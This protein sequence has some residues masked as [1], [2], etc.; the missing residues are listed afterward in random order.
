MT[1][2]ELPAEQEDRR[3]ASV[4]EA[5]AYAVAVAGSQRDLAERLSAY[6][7]LCGQAISLTPAAV[8]AWLTRCSLLQRHYWPAFEEITQGVVTRRH[9]R[10][11]LFPDA[12]PLPADDYRWKAR[13]IVS[14]INARE[15]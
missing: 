5:I 12:A 11:D 15:A 9:L 3:R 10:P 14:R 4:R 6:F 2:R 13:E 1:D 8:S 7:S